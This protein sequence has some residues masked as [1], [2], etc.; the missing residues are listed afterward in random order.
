MR[1]VYVSGLSGAGLLS[2]A[3]LPSLEATNLF[4]G[5]LRT[6]SEPIVSSC[7]LVARREA[8]NNEGHQG[9]PAG[10]AEPFQ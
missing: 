1:E 6:S 3:N 9:Q 4:G 5:W 2:K 7:E 8:R 10:I